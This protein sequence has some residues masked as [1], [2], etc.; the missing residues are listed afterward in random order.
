MIMKKIAEITPL[1]F[2]DHLIISLDR[3]WINLW[4]QV[5][6]FT[7]K[8]YD[9]AKLVLESQSNTKLQKSL[10]EKKTK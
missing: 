5:P 4:N 6:T 8:L 3:E 2:E 9:N 1:L 7:A 10:E